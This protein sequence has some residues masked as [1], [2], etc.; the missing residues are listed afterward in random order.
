MA[1][2]SDQFLRESLSYME[3]FSYEGVFSAISFKRQV[4]FRTLL[5]VLGVQS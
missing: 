5:L 1:F 2:S 3:L 4:Q